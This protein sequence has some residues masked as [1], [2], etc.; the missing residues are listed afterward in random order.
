MARGSDP[1]F[2]AMA[3]EFVVPGTLAK[4]SG[5]PTLGLLGAADVILRDLR[6][7]R[8]IPAFALRLLRKVR[9]DRPEGLKGHQRGA[10]DVLM[11]RR[12]LLKGAYS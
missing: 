3:A 5:L 7:R 2:A 9:F 10:S 8:R 6:P 4:R 11:F 12:V 1:A